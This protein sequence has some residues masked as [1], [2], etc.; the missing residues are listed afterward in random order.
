MQTW[1]ISYTTDKQKLK[2]RSWQQGKL[3]Y[4]TKTY[5]AH[6]YDEENV[7]IGRMKLKPGQVQ[8]DSEINL[9]KHLIEVGVLES[10]EACVEDLFDKINKELGIEEF[11]GKG[12]GNDEID[13]KNKTKTKEKPSRS[14][15]LKAKIPTPVN[16]NE[17]TVLFD[18]LYT[19][20]TGKITQ[21]WQDGL[22]KYHPELKLAEFYDG[23]GTLLHKKTMEV[24]AVAEGKIIEDAAGGAL[25]IEISSKRG[26]E[27]SKFASVSQTITTRQFNIL[28]TTDKHKKSK[29]WLDGRM[30]Y[31]TTTKLAKFIDESG[32]CF[33]KKVMTAEVIGVGEEFE[34]GM[35]LI[36]IDHEITE[37]NVKDNKEDNEK[38]NKKENYIV[39]L[40][41]KTKRIKSIV[42][43]ESAPF[44]GRSN[45]Q[46]LSL[47][48]KTPTTPK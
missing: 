22:L 42:S 23:K 1:S 39:S 20:S 31:V 19:R 17:I 4:N 27:T 40:G 41:N 25:L 3:N 11:K 43:D 18:I 46:L 47:L 36:Q 5:Q 44:S 6:F 8:P 12:A 29:K 28:Y 35:Y 13:S 38:D 2:N 9:W 24:E 37:G 33:Y 16:K 48:N 45:S 32:D 26:E 30:E 15:I 14:V 21:T 34:T 7:E 10:E